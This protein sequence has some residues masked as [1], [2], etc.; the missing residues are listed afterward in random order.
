[1]RH[2]HRSKALEDRKIPDKV[3]P[4]PT[5]SA[6]TSTGQHRHRREEGTVIRIFGAVMDSTIMGGSLFNYD[7][8]IRL[9]VPN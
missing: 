5:P 7:A 3:P 9:E 4:Q 1:M 8:T 2:F 6:A